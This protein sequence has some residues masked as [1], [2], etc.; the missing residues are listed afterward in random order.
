MIYIHLGGVILFPEVSFL[1]NYYLVAS[2]DTPA[3]RSSTPMG[4]QTHNVP[5]AER[6]SFSPTQPRAGREHPAKPVSGIHLACLNCGFR[7]LI[8]FAGIWIEQVTSVVTVCLLKGHLG[9]CWILLAFCCWVPWEFEN[10]RPGPL[11]HS[12]GDAY[13]Q[14]A[15]SQGAPL[16]LRF[17]EV[18]SC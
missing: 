7:S 5:A 1:R 12:P 13:S 4:L 15:Y 9:I 10:G 3:T 18:L 6:A 8:F 16:C 11:G 17:Q 2:E 14:G